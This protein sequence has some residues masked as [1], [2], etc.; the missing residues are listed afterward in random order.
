MD[1]KVLGTMALVGILVGG[2]FVLFEPPAP[3]PEEGLFIVES[4]PGNPL[5]PAVHNEKRFRVIEGTGQ[6]IQSGQADLL[7][8]R[9]SDCGVQPGHPSADLPVLWCIRD[10]DRGLAAAE[11]MDIA[12]RRWIDSQLLQEDDQDAAFPLSITLA[13][14]PRRVPIAGVTEPSEPGGSDPGGSDSGGSGGT[15]PGGADGGTGGSEPSKQP[16]TLLDDAAPSGEVQRDIRPDDVDPPFPIRSLLLTFAYVLPASLLAQ[17]QASALHG[18]R[19]R[20]RGMLILSGPVT[21]SDIIIGKSIPAIVATLL[22]GAL[23]TLLLDAG[24][25]AFMASLSFLFFLYASTTY[26]AIVSRTPRELSLSQVAVTTLLNVFLFLPAMF[27][28]IPPV[29]FLSPVHVVAA[30]IRGEAVSIGQFLYATLPLSFAAVALGALSIGLMREELLF[31]VRSA[32]QRVLDSMAV[33]TRKHWRVVAA[34]I[35]VVPFV[36]AAE[37][38][39][40]VMSAVMGIQAAFFLFLPLSVIMEEAAK[41]MVVWARYRPGAGKSGAAWLVGLL[42]GLGFFLGE[43]SYLVLTLVGFD[44]LPYG[45]EALALLGTGPGMALL[46]IPLAL[47]VGTAAILAVGAARSRGWAYGMFLLAT[48]IH[49]AWDQVLLG[50]VI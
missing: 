32:T 43:K 24:F 6:A 20:R 30:G 2:L 27:P 19:T 37:I 45:A 50:G 18:E 7:L 11:I 49:L 40:L 47:H 29:A 9:P 17:V 22:I 48:V 36:F 25:L 44:S 12:V 23:V 41:G 8:G 35:L 33:M 46:L 28:S 21:A 39:V 3:S 31:S 16:T 26:L 13:Y 42:V 4:R 10:D 14:E 38:M 1:P 15:D 34:G 5:D